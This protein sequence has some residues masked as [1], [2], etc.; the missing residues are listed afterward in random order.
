MGKDN[1]AT[2]YTISLRDNMES[3]IQDFWDEFKNQETKQNKA[4]DRRMRALLRQFQ[5]R[6][7]KPYRIGSLGKETV[8]LNSILSEEE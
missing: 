2:E 4:S 5:D 6:I 7:Y 1:E 8:G 3:F